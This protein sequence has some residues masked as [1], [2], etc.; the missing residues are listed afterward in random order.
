LKT[1]RRALILEAPKGRNQPEGRQTRSMGDTTPS[2]LRIGGSVK[3]IW[4]IAG[5]GA[6][7]VLLVLARF[8]YESTV[9]PSSA[10]QPA[11]ATDL[12]VPAGTL[13]L[14]LERQSVSNQ[15]RQGDLGTRWRHNWESRLTRAGDVAQLEEW[16]GDVEFVQIAGAAD[17]ESATGE[18]VSFDEDGSAMRTGGTG[19]VET[20]DA[21]GR[22]TQRIYRASSGNPGVVS[23][24]RDASGRLTR[25]EAGAGAHLS[26]TSDGDGRVTQV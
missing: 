21:Q 15:S 13:T 22:L 17:Y 23:L 8:F 4:L 7:L 10:T 20:F 16:T 5:T 18:H 6:L 24:S 12:E 11:A 9:T 2:R 1:A 3:P 26:F 14:R 19:I 25:V